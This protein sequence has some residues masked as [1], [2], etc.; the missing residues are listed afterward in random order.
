MGYACASTFSAQD[1][2]TN[3]AANGV[4]SCVFYDTEINGMYQCVGL[5]FALVAC[6]VHKLSAHSLLHSCMQTGLLWGVK[7][8]GRIQAL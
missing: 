5:V 8:Y 7:W 3:D 4:I 2:N 1:T 6:S